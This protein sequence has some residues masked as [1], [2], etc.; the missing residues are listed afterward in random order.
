MFSFGESVTFEA[1]VVGAE[2]DHGNPIESYGPPMVVDYCAFDP[3][4]SVESFS[5]GR[6]VVSTTPRVFTPASAT[7]SVSP[8]DRV[9]V[10]GLVYQVKG[11]PQVWVNP[12]TG[13]HPGGVIN[14]ERTA[15]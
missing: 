4:V 11:D 5:P 10:R 13:W 3:G 8:R 14:L 7:V 15:G 9:T 2:D 6:D 1:L 12:F